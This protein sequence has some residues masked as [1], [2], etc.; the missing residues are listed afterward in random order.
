MMRDE[1]VCAIII[2]FN[3]VFHI[4]APLQTGQTR[5]ESGLQCTNISD[6][7]DIKVEVSIT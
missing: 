6:E 3:A 2:S 1:I 4:S 7:F 5:S